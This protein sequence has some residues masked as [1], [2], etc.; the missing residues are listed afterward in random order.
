MY[1]ALLFRSSSLFSPLLGDIPTTLESNFCYKPKSKN[2][3][4][5]RLALAEEVTPVESEFR[6]EAEVVRQVRE[7]DMDLEPARPTT[8]QQS[9]PSLPLHDSMEDVSEDAMLVDSNGIGLSSSFKQQAQKNSKGR[10]FWETFS[11]TSSVGGA[12]TTPPPPGPPPRGS[13]SGMSLEDI[14]MDSPSLHPQKVE[15]CGGMMMFPM[16]TASSSGGDTPQG[17]NG[18]SSIPP[19]DHAPPS[20]A[21]ITR[22]FNMGKR[23]RDDDLDPVSFKRRAVSPGM[24]VHNSPV[25]QSPMQHAPWGPR[26]GSNGGDRSGGGTPSDNGAGGSGSGGSGSGS[27]EKRPSVHKG[28][29]GYQGMI[30]TNDGITRL[31]IE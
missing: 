14:M 15:N 20:A 1:M 27:G 4:R 9:S 12:R 28:R 3:A 21:E 8:A 2:F 31:S 30:D 17:P 19:S 26:P 13:S 24:S 25:M 23:R 7:S 16:T 6:R 10:M 18:S 22:R 29:V 5:V 11:E